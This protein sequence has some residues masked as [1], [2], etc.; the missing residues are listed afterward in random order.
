M[1]SIVICSLLFFTICLWL[2]VHFGCFRITHWLLFLLQIEKAYVHPE[3]DAHIHMQIFRTNISSLKL[4]VGYLSALMSAV[5]P[6]LPL[7]DLSIFKASRPSPS[8]SPCSCPLCVS[9]SYGSPTRH[10]T[11]IPLWAI[12]FSLRLVKCYSHIFTPPD[13]HHHRLSVGDNLCYFS[14]SL[15]YIWRQHISDATLLYSSDSSSVN[16]IYV[17]FHHHPTISAPNGMSASLAILKN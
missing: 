5:P 13:S 1:F 6:D 2:Y 10:K 7:H 8:Q 16:Y 3:S 15:P 17:Y 11:R 4:P 14:S 12:S 9:C